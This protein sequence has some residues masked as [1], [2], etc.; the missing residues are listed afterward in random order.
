ME[1]Y[2]VMRST[3]S[4]REFSDQPVPDEVLT[5]IFENARF[6][7][8]GGNRQGERVIVIRDAPAKAALAALA[9]PA[10]KRYAAQV[11]AGEAPWNTVNPTKVDAETVARTPAPRSLTETLA[12]APVLLVV[13]VDLRVVASTDQDLDRIGVIS[14]ASIY[15]FVQN[16]LLAARNEGYGGTLTTIVIAAEPEVKTL[17]GIPDGVAVCAVVPLG[18]PVQRLRRLKRRPVSAFAVHERWDGAPLDTPA[19]GSEDGVGD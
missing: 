19:Q 15:P 11:A 16:I 13:C 5:R 7:S 12:R 14:G 3:F 2:E 1:L 4:A 6:A 10:A 8:S 18:R 9:V 17:L